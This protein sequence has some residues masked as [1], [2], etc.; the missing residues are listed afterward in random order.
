MPA[1][2][3]FVK[4]G[5]RVDGLADVKG[6]GRA[7]AVAGVV[8]D[9]VKQRDELGGKGELALLGP[10]SGK[11]SE[12]GALADA[13]LEDGGRLVIKSGDDARCRGRRGGADR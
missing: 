13:V 6:R 3:L 2:F 11:E 7:D 1:F 10:P 12:D 8:E 4:A 9:R 5:L